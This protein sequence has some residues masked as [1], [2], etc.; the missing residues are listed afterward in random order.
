MD[1]GFFINYK[2]KVVQLPVNP[3]KISVKFNG[4]NST[5]EVIKLGDINLL[6]DRKLAEISF[7][8]FFPYDKWFSAIRTKGD[9]KR[10]KFYKNFFEDIMNDKK[11][12]RL[13]VTGLNINMKCSIE[14]FEYHHQAGDHEDA[15]YSIELKEY[16]DY[17]IAEIKIKEKSTSNSNKKKK[18]KPAPAKSVKPEK[19]TVGCTVI[20][21]GRVHY[22]SY[23]AKPGKTFKNYTGKVNFI[24]KS[25]SHPYHITTPEG[26]WLGWVTEKSVKLK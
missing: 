5:T 8:S 12:C 23:G 13:V 15:Y 7:E 14:S 6:K 20:L 17:D 25:G 21:N 16:R 4:N 3:E 19:I 11:P 10:P 9:F 24:N 1:I 26:G 22:D 2:K 18:K